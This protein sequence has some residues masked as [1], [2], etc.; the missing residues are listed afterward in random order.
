MKAMLSI[1]ENKLEKWIRYSSRSVNMEGTY[2]DVMQIE[3]CSFCNYSCVFC[4]YEKMTRPKGYMD[5]G[6]YK[7]IIDQ[8]THVNS[9]GL[10]HM[11]EPLLHPDI[12]IFIFSILYKTLNIRVE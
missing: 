1:D 7:S 10:H 9:I 2:P 6:L 8:C 12:D 3:L 4:P 11:G 5:I